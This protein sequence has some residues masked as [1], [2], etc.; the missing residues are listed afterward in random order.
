MSGRFFDTRALEMLRNMHRAYLHLIDSGGDTLNARVQVA[1]EI[2]FKRVVLDFP[3]FDQ[4]LIADWAE[5]VAVAMDERA[6]LIQFPRRYAYMALRGKVRGWSRTGPGRAEL[7][8]IG[9]DL[10]EVAGVT[11]SSAD[12]TEREL[13][14]E[15]ILPTLSERDRAILVLLQNEQST[16]A[17]AAF[18][19]MNYAAAAKA[20]QRVKDRV[21]VELNGNRH[22]AG[23]QARSR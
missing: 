17:I 10:E 20:M 8:G 5:E 4:A 12:Q 13:L 21:S 15:Q 1:C 2:A 23:K 3:N 18:F 16:T 22:K 11:E 6:D 9:P 14:F 7:I 19:N